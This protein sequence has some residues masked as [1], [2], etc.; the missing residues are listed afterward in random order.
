M[1]TASYYCWHHASLLNCSLLRSVCSGESCGNNPARPP[2]RPQLAGTLTQQR[3]KQA[4]ERDQSGRGCPLSPRSHLLGR[5]RCMRGSSEGRNGVAGSEEQAFKAR[6][7]GRA[8][9]HHFLPHGWLHRGRPTRVGGLAGAR[10]RTA[11]HCGVRTAEGS[12]GGGPTRVAQASSP[13]CGA[14]RFPEYRVAAAMGSPPSALAGQPCSQA[15]HHT[16]Q[17]RRPAGEGRLCGGGRAPAACPASQT[18]LGH[19]GCGN[20]PG[21]SAPAWRGWSALLVLRHAAPLGWGAQA[22]QSPLVG[23]RRLRQHLLPIG[24]PPAGWE[25]AALPAHNVGGTPAAT[26]YSW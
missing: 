3:Q 19:F 4:D 8:R 13:R 24:I 15:L 20:W 23:C 1:L 17:G 6:R 9:T 10:R 26:L 5:Q 25:P 11:R 2:T 12:R 21:G 22:P 18:G 7:R 16:C 14:A